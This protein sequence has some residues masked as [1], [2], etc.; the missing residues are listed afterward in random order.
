MGTAMAVYVGRGG[1]AFAVS[2]VLTAYFLGMTVFAPVWGAVADVTGRRRAVMVGT[3]LVATLL[4]LPLTVV[5]GVWGPI[6]LRA[7]YA[8]FAV[9]FQPVMLAVVSDLGGDEAR[10][11]SLGFFN[12]ARGVGF[13]GGQVAA[14][15]LLGLLA[16]AGLY[17]AIAGLSLVS[18]VAAALVSDPAPA[19]ERTPSVRA[20]GA[21]IR[22]RLLPAVEDREHLRT[23]GLWWLYVALALRNMT[24]LGVMSLMPV[25][26]VDTVLAG[27]VDLLGA[28]LA[29]ELV[30][31]VL[32]AIN[33]TGQS[34]FMVLFGRVADSSGRK[35]LIVAGMAGSGAFALVEAAAALPAG[36]WPRLALAGLGMVVIAAAFSAM[37]TGALAFI[38]DVAPQE[39]RSELMG[40]RS[41]AKGVGGVVGPPTI[42]AVATVAGMRAAFAVGSA[43]AFLAAALVA[44]TLAESRPGGVAPDERSVSTPAMANDD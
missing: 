22:R 23:N 10:G 7:L 13:A 29:A 20:V 16:P 25:Y 37:T 26:L 6:G 32:L 43:L 19:P 4:V 27:G 3:S 1:S 42:G 41:T 2:M 30:M 40:L 9:G 36:L 39:R 15:V 34:V 28:V 44:R 14:G 35:P 5:E 17:L 31:G 18:T 8:V 11:R 33:P 24:V 12:S 38:G 21:E